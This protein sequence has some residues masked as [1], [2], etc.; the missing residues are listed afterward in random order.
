MAVLLHGYVRPVE[1]M[2]DIRIPTTA[3]E[4]FQFHALSEKVPRIGTEEGSASIN[5]PLG[6]GVG[7]AV[8]VGVGVGVCVGIAVGE[9]NG[10]GAEVGVGVFCPQKAR[11]AMTEPAAFA[12][13]LVSTSPLSS[14]VRSPFLRIKSFNCVVVMRG[15]AA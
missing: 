1:S 8:A 14:G 6:W 5:G 2:R 4:R 3:S 10:S 13:A 11:A 15:Q 9:P 12:V 7:V